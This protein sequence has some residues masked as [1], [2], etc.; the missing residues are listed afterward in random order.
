[1]NIILSFPKGNKTAET[2]LLS[3]SERAFLT[4]PDTALLGK[5]RPFFIPDFAPQ[6]MAHLYVAVRICR[7]GRSIHKRFASRYYDSF[8]PAVQFTAHPLAEQLQ[9]EGL[10]WSMAYGFDSSLALGDFQ[11][12]TTRE[13]VPCVALSLKRNGQDVSALHMED[14][15]KEIDELIEQ[16]SLFYTLRQGDLFL[17]GSSTPIEVHID[18]HLEVLLNG[19]ANLAFNVK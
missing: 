17:I 1:M 18:D 5:K 3:S 19:D 6:C 9:E 2:T 12:L 14:I 4:I 10:P 7:L 11:H 16:A 13:S 15:S 8:A